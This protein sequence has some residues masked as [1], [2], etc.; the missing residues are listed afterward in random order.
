MMEQ[1]LVLQIQQWAHSLELRTGFPID[2]FPITY[3]E[4][5]WK[6]L[7]LGTALPNHSNDSTS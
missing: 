1:F 6:L 7:S 2:T 3:M 5:P 4:G